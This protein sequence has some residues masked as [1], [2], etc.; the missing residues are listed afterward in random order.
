MEKW[1]AIEGFEG[2]YEVSDRG[3]IRR[4]DGRVLKLHRRSAYLYIALHDCGRTKSYD[5]HRLV[6]RAF[7]AGWSPDR[8]EVNH[9]NLNKMDNRAENLEWVSRT[10]NVRHAFQNGAVKNHISKRVKKAILC[11]ELDL[12]FDSSYQAAEYLNE[13]FFAQSKD[14]PTMARNIRW[15]VSGHRTRYAYGFH[16]TDV[17]LE[18]S[19]TIPKGSTPKRVE[20]GDP[21]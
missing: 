12:T 15:R 16:W 9:K 18:S 6:A 11:R 1:K 7:C 13:H 8:N 5:V 3:R 19:T 10:E 21:S 20:M 17:S 14:V 4:T 2:L